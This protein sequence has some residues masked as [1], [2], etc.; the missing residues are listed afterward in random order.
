MMMKLVVFIFAIIATFAFADTS[1]P[2]VSPSVPSSDL[3]VC[4]SLSQNAC[5]ATNGTCGWKK[6]SCQ[7]V[8]KYRTIQTCQADSRCYWKAPSEVGDDSSCKVLS[9]VK[10]KPPTGP[11]KTKS[12]ATP[13]VTPS[14]APHAEDHSG[15]KASRSPVIAP[16]RAPQT[17]HKGGGGGG[18]SD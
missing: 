5:K 12:P 18:E 10:T 17:N 7:L 11:K 2:S 9:E 8:C 4:S 3:I 16:S 15:G 14:R 13:V 6:R 1:A